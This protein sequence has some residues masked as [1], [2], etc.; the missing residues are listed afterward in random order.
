VDR[1]DEICNAL[2]EYKINVE[3]QQKYC[4]ERI[5]I[6]RQYLNNEVAIQEKRVAAEEK[7]EQIIDLF[8]QIEKD[9]IN[10]NIKLEENVVNQLEESRQVQENMIRGF[11]E[12]RQVQERMVE[13]LEESQKYE[14]QTR[15]IIENMQTQLNYSEQ[16]EKKLDDAETKL[17]RLEAQVSSSE[18]ERTNLRRQLEE[19]GREFQQWKEEFKD[20][21][22]ELGYYNIFKKWNGKGKDSIGSQIK[23]TSFSVFLATCSEDEILPYIY[24]NV[25]VLLRKGTEPTAI[26]AINAVIDC[27]I[28]IHNRR[29]N[30]QLIRQEVAEGD[31]YEQRLHNKNERGS[32]FGK[33]EKI[34]LQ[35]VLNDGSIYKNCKAYVDITD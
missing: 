25:E 29:G 4:E 23:D 22:T 26:N 21:D 18:E 24:D 30:G 33:V 35:G 11:E 2:K 5:Q 20:L 16:N 19:K 14:E 27:C 10:Q 7:L 1:I 3:G 17:R 15:I 6:V 28:S 32:Y 9:S 34:I 12:S 8:L 13:K 31:S